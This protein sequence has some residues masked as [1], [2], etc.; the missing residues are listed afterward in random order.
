MRR[1][2]APLR[3]CMASA[4]AE[5][6]IRHNPTLGVALPARDEQ[7]RIDDGR[8]LEEEERVKALTDD[9]LAT[10]LAVCPVRWRTFF[11]LLAATGLRRSSRSAGLTC[12]SMATARTSRCAARAYGVSWVRRRASTA[13]GR[14]RS[15][16]T[17]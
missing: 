4:V 10:F 16:T 3:A 12:S 5:G 1:V 2:L 8:D 7:R 11:A 9:E 13:A 17:S 6:V 15:V 14:S